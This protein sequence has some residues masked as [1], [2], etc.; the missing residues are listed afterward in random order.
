MREEGR[1]EKEGEREAEGR[2]ERSVIICDL[3]KPFQ[4]LMI[5]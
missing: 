2:K 1:G 4:K 5:D 3:V